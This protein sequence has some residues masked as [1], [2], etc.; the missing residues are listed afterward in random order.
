[1]KIFQRFGI[2]HWKLIEK[3]PIQEKVQIKSFRQEINPY[4]NSIIWAE[5]LI[6]LN[7][8]ISSDD[9]D[10]PKQSTSSNEYSAMK[11]INREKRRFSAQ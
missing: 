4:K 8:S 2:I 3:I 1:M 6:D 9:K 5:N 10:S 11:I 7:I